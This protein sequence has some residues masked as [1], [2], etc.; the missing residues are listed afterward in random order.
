MSDKQFIPIM[1]KDGK[2]ILPDSYNS[3]NVVDSILD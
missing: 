3:S 2:P 1:G